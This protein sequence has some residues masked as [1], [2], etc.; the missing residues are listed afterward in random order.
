MRLAAIFLGAT[1]QK[2]PGSAV[3]FFSISLFWAQ[4]LFLFFFP[5][6][7]GGPEPGGSLVGILHS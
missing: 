2:G 6:V 7:P 4:P 3:D 1:W 5:T